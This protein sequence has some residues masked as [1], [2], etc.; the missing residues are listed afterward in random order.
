MFGPFHILRAS[1]LKLVFSDETLGDA[2]SCLG[3]ILPGDFLDPEE[4]VEQFH[5]IFG[6]TEL[7]ISGN[8]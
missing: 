5:Q 2:A 4:N 7:S 3:Q 1:Q 8:I 6:G